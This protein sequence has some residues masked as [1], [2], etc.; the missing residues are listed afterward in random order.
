MTDITCNAVANTGDK[1]GAPAME[2]G[3][4]FMHSPNHAEEAKIARLK[5]GLNRRQLP[6]IGSY[7]DSVKTAN[8]LL[9]YVNAALADARTIEGTI[10][11]LQVTASLLRIA[12]DILPLVDVGARLTVLEGMIYADNQNVRK[13]N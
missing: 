4:C 6:Q 2:D 9:D 5:G 12:V 7:P 1:C 3:F 8:Q 13:T 10:Q 11:R